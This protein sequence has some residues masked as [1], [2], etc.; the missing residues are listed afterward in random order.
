MA[1]YYNVT[2]GPADAI[3]IGLNP[4]N[5]GSNVY[6]EI[7]NGDQYELRPTEEIRAL[8]LPNS[9]VV[10]SGDIIQLLQKD[11]RIDSEV[12]GYYYISSKNSSEETEK[13]SF[14]LV[15]ID[16]SWEN[17]EFDLHWIKIFSDEYSYGA[18]TDGVYCLPHN[19]QTEDVEISGNLT[20]SNIM[21]Y[22][23]TLTD[24]VN[25]S[26]VDYGSPGLGGDGPYRLKVSYKYPDQDNTAVSGFSDYMY[27]GAGSGSAG[28]IFDVPYYDPRSEFREIPAIYNFDINYISAGPLKGD[29]KP[30]ILTLDHQKL[31]DS[32][33]Y[34]KNLDTQVFNK[35]NI[36][37]LKKTDE[38]IINDNVINRKRISFGVSDISVVDNTYQK[39]GVY[40]SSFYPLEFSPY[41]FSLKVKESIPKY[42]NL[43]PYDIVRYYIEFNSN[44]WERISPLSRTDELES[45]KVVPK[46]FVFD[47]GSEDVFGSQ[48]K[49]LNYN[50][51][52]NGFRV[53]ITFDLE[54]LID[55]KFSPPEIK[56]YK[57]VLFDKSQFLQL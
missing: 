38:I 11:H 2:I 12:D 36:N 37:L 17:T 53:K 46:M 20:S 50:S 54:S 4:I 32:S 29:T 24:I 28:L 34:F 43:D 39:N 26:S 27:Y 56:D 49:F 52:I 10:S 14:P 57:C 7:T 13:V 44:V 51:A 45:G 41:T 42:P 23:V 15:N 18:Y 47:K 33:M 3:D 55:A 48:I 25:D 22:K 30:L 21:Q 35:P 5:K 6:M 8:L 9:V 19:P 16:R 1:N 40:V 31:L